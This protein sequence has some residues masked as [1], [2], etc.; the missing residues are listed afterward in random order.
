MAP[1]F[2]GL[3]SISEMVGFKSLAKAEKFIISR[4]SASSKKGLETKISCTHEAIVFNLF[5]I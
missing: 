5:I 2:T 3:R 1:S 4:E